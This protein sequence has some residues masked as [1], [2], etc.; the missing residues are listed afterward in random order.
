VRTSA[1]ESITRSPSWN[2][3]SARAHPCGYGKFERLTPAD[4]STL[5][6]IERAARLPYL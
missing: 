2:M 1:L 6:D 5:T 3:L 4:P